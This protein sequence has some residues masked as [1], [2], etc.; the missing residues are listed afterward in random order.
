M[1]K[2][3]M[4]RHGQSA[5]NEKNIFTGWVDIPLSKKGIDE[6]LSAGEKIDCIPFDIIFVSN[7]IRAQ[8]TAFLALSCSKVEKLPCMIHEKDSKHLEWAK[9]HDPKVEKTLIPVYAKYELNERMY[10]ELQGLHKGETLKKFGEEQ[11]R[12]WR[13]SYYVHPPKGESLEMTAKRAIPFFESTI[14]PLLKEKKN[15]LI[16]AHGNSLRA[17]VMFI[18]KLSEDEVVKLEI[19][20]GEPLCYDFDY[21]GNLKKESIDYCNE[22][23]KNK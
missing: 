4:I 11:Y 6:S 13:R 20:T 22:F 5:W 8:M 18:E 21:K 1:A 12:L 14:L 15:I 2:L 9:V 17:I 10:G 19:P 3:V 7:L 23:F 16:S